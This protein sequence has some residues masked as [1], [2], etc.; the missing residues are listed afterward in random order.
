MSA[1]LAAAGGL[2]PVSNRVLHDAE[3]DIEAIGSAS[4]VDEH[5][6]APREPSSA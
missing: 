6:R 1:Q 5:N 3:V 2:F 4:L